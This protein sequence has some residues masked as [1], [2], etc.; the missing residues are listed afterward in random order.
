[1]SNAIRLE[2]FQI[3]SRLDPA[4]IRRQFAL[5]ALVGLAVL[6]GVAAHGLQPARSAVAVDGARHQYVSAPQF[7]VPRSAPVVAQRPT[8]FG[9]LASLD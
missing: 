4:A 3:G 1:M 2:A 5:S 8:I 7:V 6:A 9:T